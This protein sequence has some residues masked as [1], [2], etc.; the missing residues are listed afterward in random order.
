MVGSSFSVLVRR[1]APRATKDKA[2]CWITKPMIIGA[3]T[4]AAALSPTVRLNE[5]F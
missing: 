1:A 3:I 2:G 5:D 4:K